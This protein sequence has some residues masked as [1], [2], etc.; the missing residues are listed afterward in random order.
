M[1][2]SK[3]GELEG[4]KASQAQTIINTKINFQKIL[5]GI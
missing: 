1:F 5:S 3:G 2:D 4:L